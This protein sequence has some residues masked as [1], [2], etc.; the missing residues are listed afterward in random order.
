M[1]AANF[2]QALKVVYYNTDRFRVLWIKL[3]ELENKVM[4][5]LEYNKEYNKYM[6]IIS[7]FT[8]N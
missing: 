6:E 4:I 5:E 2:F 3:W 7:S 8:N 1:S